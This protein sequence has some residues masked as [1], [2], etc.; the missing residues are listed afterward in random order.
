MSDENFFEYDEKNIKKLLF[1]KKQ[2]HCMI[3]GNFSLIFF[4]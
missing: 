4:I 2:S 1:Y 3:F